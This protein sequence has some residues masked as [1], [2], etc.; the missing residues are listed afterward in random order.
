MRAENYSSSRVS[1]VYRLGFTCL[2]SCGRVSIIFLRWQQNTDFSST[3]TANIYVGTIFEACCT[4]QFNFLLN[5]F[6]S[7]FFL[8]YHWAKRS[9]T[10]FNNH[11]WS[12]VDGKERNGVHPT[13]RGDVENSSFFP[14]NKAQVMIL[15]NKKYI[16][17]KKRKKKNWISGEGG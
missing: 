15:Y 9:V 11:L 12:G 2:Y 5:S 7:K 17:K 14:R 8:K 10:K 4:I 16:L 3:A 1:R 6:S 13:G